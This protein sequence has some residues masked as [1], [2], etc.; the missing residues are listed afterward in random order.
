MLGASDFAA[1]APAMRRLSWPQRSPAIGIM[2]MIVTKVEVTVKFIVPVDDSSYGYTLGEGEFD[3]HEIVNEW[4][5]E[6]NDNLKFPGD[7]EFITG[8]SV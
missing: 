8:T 7:Y 6:A 4:L 2:R 5:I 3:A 1:L